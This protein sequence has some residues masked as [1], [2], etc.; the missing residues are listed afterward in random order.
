MTP[1]GN[2]LPSSSTKHQTDRFILMDETHVAGIHQVG[3]CL[4]DAPGKLPEG[5]W[6]RATYFWIISRWSE[7]QALNIDRAFRFSAFP[8]FALAYQ[9]DVAL[10]SASE[11][12]FWRSWRTKLLAMK[13]APMLLGVIVPEPCFSL[14]VGETRTN[15]LAP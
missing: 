6:T 5:L 1:S 12:L 3:S 8:C 4:P 2:G 10:H 15:Q 13:Q 11:A 9:V 14:H 7:I